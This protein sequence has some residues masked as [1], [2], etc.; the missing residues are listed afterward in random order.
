VIVLDASAWVRSLVDAGPAGAAARATLTNDPVWAAPAHMPI[1]ILRTIRRYESARI[2]DT[3]QA[4]AFA[5]QVSG[6]EVRYAQ[7]E[8][9]MLGAI[10]RRRHN[11]SPYDAAYV[12]LA[13]YYD[14][15]LVT[16]DERLAK[17]AAAAG[18]TATVPRT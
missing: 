2:I 3:E 17:A 5:A 1:E 9:W 14:V 11:I 12:A 18:V 13:G 15:P 10:W 6:A 16:L 8:E 4:D 7:P